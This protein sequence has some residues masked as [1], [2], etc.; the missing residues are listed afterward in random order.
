MGPSGSTHGGTCGPEGF[1]LKRRIC[2]CEAFLKE[3][4]QSLARPS[5]V[6]HHIR[7]GVGNM[8]SMDTA[9]VPIV[10]VVD[11]VVATRHRLWR[12]LSL[13]FGVLEAPDARRARD[14]LTYRPNIDALV[15][16]MEL[17]DA[18]GSDLVKS[19]ATAQVAVASRAILVARPVDLRTVVTRLA[20]WF[21]SRDAARAELLWREADRLC[22]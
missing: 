2:A 15:V 16:Q 18:Q 11:P 3:D 14:W 9:R 12:L 7:P 13:S 4:S 5:G 21:F 1:A 8:F 10:L 17:P 20:G 19:F 22:S 6:S